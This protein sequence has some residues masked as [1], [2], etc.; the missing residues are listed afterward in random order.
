MIA[1]DNFENY[2]NTISA[3]T[4]NIYSV[5]FNA[6]IPVTIKPGSLLTINLSEY[7]K[8]EQLK[9]RKQG[10]LSWH[11]QLEKPGC[12]CFWLSYRKNDGSIF[13]DHSF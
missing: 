3:G 4:L 13:G 8:F 7:K 2:N 12:E 6:K 9:K 11:L 10:F 5:N 1:N